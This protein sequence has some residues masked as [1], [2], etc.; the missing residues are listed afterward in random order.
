MRVPITKDVDPDTL[1]VQMTA[2]LGRPVALS[3]R[4]TG[5]VD[6][7]GNPLPGVVVLLD[8]GTGTELADQDPRAVA[9]V[10]AG[11]VVPPPPKT[12]A[13][14]LADALA[15]AGTVADVRGAL[16]AFAKGITD[17]E[18]LARGR[19]RKAS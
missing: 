2:A 6:N 13:K 17:Q 19:R 7:D 3:V 4:N 11:H 5:E 16:V 9:N 12:P 8:A 15:T 18:D 1:A 14:A 10:L